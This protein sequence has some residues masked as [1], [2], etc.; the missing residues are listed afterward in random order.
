MERRHARMAAVDPEH[1]R[2]FLATYSQVEVWSTNNLAPQSGARPKTETG[3]TGETEQG[4]SPSNTEPQNT[5]EGD[6]PPK[7]FPEMR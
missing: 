7:P 4:V 6:Y 3:N 2:L 1:E 5:S